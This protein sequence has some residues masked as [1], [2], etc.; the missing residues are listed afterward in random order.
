MIETLKWSYIPMDW[1]S[2]DGGWWQQVFLIEAPQYLMGL[3]QCVPL[4]DPKDT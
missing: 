1:F 3:R 4:S 2:V